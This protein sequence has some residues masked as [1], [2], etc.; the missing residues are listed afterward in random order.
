LLQVVLEQ[1]ATIARQEKTIARLEKEVAELKEMVAE[2]LRRNKRQAAPFSRNQFVAKPKQAGRKKGTRYGTKARRLKPEQID[3]TLIAP[4]PA[5]CPKCQERL[6]KPFC[7]ALKEKMDS[8]FRGNDGV[9]HRVLPANISF[10]RRLRQVTFDRHLNSVSDRA[11]SH[12]CPT[13]ICDQAWLLQALRLH[14][15]RPTSAAMQ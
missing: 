5:N 10:E 3:E 4:L 12:A 9:L 15:A 6:S 7:S 14:G 1:D 11:A 8:R 13:R 2:L